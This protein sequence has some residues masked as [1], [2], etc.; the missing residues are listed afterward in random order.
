MI[1]GSYYTDYDRHE[2][3]FACVLSGGMVGAVFFWGSQIGD[4]GGLATVWIE[5]TDKRCV[6]FN[7]Y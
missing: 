3:W 1:A 5:I 2:M 6:Q 4:D 7:E